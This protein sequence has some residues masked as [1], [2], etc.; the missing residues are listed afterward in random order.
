M[1]VLDNTAISRFHLPGLD[2]QTLAGPERSS[3]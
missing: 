3:W 2:H 1:P